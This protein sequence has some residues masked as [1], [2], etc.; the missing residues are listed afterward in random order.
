MFK[1]A[2]YIP[3]LLKAGNWEPSNNNITT[4]ATCRNVKFQQIMRYQ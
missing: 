4:E 3:R 1:K 2:K